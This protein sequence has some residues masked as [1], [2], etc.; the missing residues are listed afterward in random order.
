MLFLTLLTCVVAVIH[1]LNRGRLTLSLLILLVPLTL[2]SLLSVF[3]LRAGLHT[4]RARTDGIRGKSI[5]CAVLGTMM[6]VAFVDTI[7]TGKPQDGL[8]FMVMGFFLCVSGFVGIGA[9]NDYKRWLAWPAPT[10]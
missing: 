9:S 4:L 8:V 1:N 7:V 2:N 5:V 6:L 10:P 3:L